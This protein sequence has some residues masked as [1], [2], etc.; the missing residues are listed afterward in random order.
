MLHDKPTIISMSS[1]YG[2]VSSKHIPLR[3]KHISYYSVRLLTTWCTL[4]QTH[5]QLLVYFIRI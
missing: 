2:S 1:A 5:A 4:N 3:L